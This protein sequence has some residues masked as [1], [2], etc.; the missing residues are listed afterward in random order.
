[1]P[2]QN[3]ESAAS[4]RTMAALLAVLL[5]VLAARAEEAAALPP[6]G[7]WDGKTASA[8]LDVPY[9]DPV[10][11]P[12][13]FGIVSY[14]N[15]PWRGYMDTW[16]ASRWLNF[17]GATFMTWKMDRLRGLAKLLAECG[18]RHTRIE[19]GWGHLQWNDDLSEQDKQR[20]KVVF[21][22][23]KESGIRPM[24]LLNAHH[25]APCPAQYFERALA[26]P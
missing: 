6:V 18:V 20:F 5:T 4:G 22:L 3:P 2:I 15:H 11:T 26:A 19:I 12:P 10:Q 21:A 8:K 9:E 14:Y 7:C 13:P 17:P 1:M 16:P 25:G 23:L 24:I